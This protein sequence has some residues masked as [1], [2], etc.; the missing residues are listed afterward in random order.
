[1]MAKVNIGIIVYIK[2]QDLYLL[3]TVGVENF[4]ENM[5]ELTIGERD[6]IELFYIYSS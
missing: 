5:I 3:K 4:L 6:Q 2:D 1:M